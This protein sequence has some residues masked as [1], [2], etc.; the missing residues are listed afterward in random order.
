MSTVP[1]RVGARAAWMGEW[2]HKHRPRDVRNLCRTHSYFVLGEIGWSMPSPVSTSYLAR[3]SSAVRE[4]ARCCQACCSLS[5]VH[6]S[7][8]MERY[9][10]Q[11]GDYEAGMSPGRDCPC[12][13]REEFAAKWKY[14]LLLVLVGSALRGFHNSSYFDM[15]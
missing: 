7:R 6:V 1:L 8:F 2:S 13:S 9:K 3:D 12:S 15:L 4:A 11:G 5:C 14:G 10:G